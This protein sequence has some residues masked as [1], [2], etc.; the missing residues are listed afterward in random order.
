MIHEGSSHDDVSDVCSQ[1]YALLIEKRLSFSFIQVKPLVFLLH[2]DCTC[3]CYFLY[4]SESRVRILFYEGFF[5]ITYLLIQSTGTG[6]ELHDLPFGMI[7]KILSLG[8]QY[9]LFEIR[10]IVKNFSFMFLKKPHRFL[11]G[12]IEA[13]LCNSKSCCSL[14]M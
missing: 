3:K 7:T 4:F 2:I 8:A 10:D 1:I 9:F 6:K 13:S 5:Q 12:G 14:L 11:Q